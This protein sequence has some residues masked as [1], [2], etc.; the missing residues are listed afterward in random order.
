MLKFPPLPLLRAALAIG[1]LA[2]S[3]CSPQY[4]WREVR[5]ADA[6]FVAVLPAKPATYSRPVNLDGIQ[7]AMTMTAAEVAGV[8]FAIGTAQL[9]DAAK[10]QAALA[11]M[12]TAL[13]KNIGGTIRHEKASALMPGKMT[14]IE[15]EANGA[16]SAA[17]GGQPRLLLA[18]FIA[19]DQRVYQL[20]V[21]G[22]EQAV[23]RETVDTFFTSFKLN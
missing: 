1:A 18:R 16:P 9:P 14:S 13:V 11:A 6:P 7:V 17:A 22:P 3:A 2:L 8:T 10:A 12:K 21:V 15:I 23:S 19:Q 4:D 20:V 5:S